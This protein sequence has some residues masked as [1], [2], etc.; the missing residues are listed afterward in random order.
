MLKQT[1][2]LLTLVIC[3]TAGA[4]T[5][6][7]VKGNKIV[8][9]I[10]TEIDPFHSIIV[11]EDFEIEIIYNHSPSV[12]IETDENLHEYVKFDVYNGVLSFDKTAKITSKKRLNIT[13][14]HDATLSNIK[15]LDK[16]ELTSLT[17][18]ELPNAILIAEGSAKAGLTIK[19]SQ[20]E[21]QGKDKSKIKLNLTCEDAKLNLTDNSR[22]DALIYAPI[23]AADLYM[24]ATANIEGETDDLQI[25]TDNF[26][27]FN[28]KNFTAKTCTT[29]NEISSDAY[30]EVLDTVTINAS[31]NS[32]IY[33]YGN[34]KITINKL[35]NT[36]K[37]QKK[38]K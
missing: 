28:G 30:I 36:S 2:T 7:K 14:N 34:P 4:Q 16:G 23:T 13:V 11:D 19:T 25:R 20:F 5:I 26:S 10:T 3:F 37:L 17:T 32:S 27:T 24:R 21:F 35:D 31:G 1:I 9:I 22:M 15:I 33:L 29:L 38:E 6:E 18:M 8:T 12:T